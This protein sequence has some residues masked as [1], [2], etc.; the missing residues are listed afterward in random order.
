MARYVIRYNNSEGMPAAW[1]CW[2]EDAEEAL[3]KFDAKH[4]DARVVCCWRTE[5]AQAVNEAREAV[6]KAKGENHV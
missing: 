6:R 5:A 2:A 3:E 4:A 1:L